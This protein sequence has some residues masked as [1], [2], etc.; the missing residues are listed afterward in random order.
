MTKLVAAASLLPPRIR[1]GTVAHARVH[2]VLTLG[3]A[4]SLATG[5]AWYGMGEAGRSWLLL[6]LGLLFG[7]YVI[8]TRNL[9]SRLLEGSTLALVAWGATMPFWFP[10]WHDQVRIG[11]SS[12]GAI[13][14]G[15][16]GSEAL[17]QLGY[18]SDAIE[19]A[20]LALPLAVLIAGCVT[21]VMLLVTTSSPA[22]LWRV[23][24]GSVLAAV[25][26]AIPR[27]PV[28]GAQAS[29]VVWH[30][31]ACSALTRWA[32]VQTRA[33]SAGFC[34]SCGTD[35]GGMAS[36]I[37]PKCKR[38]LKRGPARRKA[39][40]DETM[41]VL[42]ASLVLRGGVSAPGGQGDPAQVRPDAPQARPKAA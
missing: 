33:R 22:V 26:L 5:L 41:P 37:C 17:G 19:P 9:A 7:A 1:P 30:A 25:A 34:P 32:I 10:V 15:F 24:L 14:I 20:A 39:T 4:V 29:V 36:P 2:G 8:A 31:C 35:V 12:A 6:A 42:G 3:L 27:W 16:L 23:A 21:G 38:T 13:Q 28:T 18:T 40:E 11:L